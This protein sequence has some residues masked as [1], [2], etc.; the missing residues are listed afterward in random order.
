M[1]IMDN[2]YA[3]IG[4]EEMAAIY[5]EEDAPIGGDEN[6]LIPQDDNPVVR[7]DENEEAEDLEEVQVEEEVS[8]V[9]EVEEDVDDDDAEE[10]EEEYEY[11]ED[12]LDEFVEIDTDEEQNMDIDNDEEEDE[13]EEEEEEEEDDGHE[14]RID[15]EQWVWEFNRREPIE[16]PAVRWEVENTPFWMLAIRET[17]RPIQWLLWPSDDFL[18]VL[19]SCL[20]VVTVIHL[21]MLTYEVHEQTFACRRVDYSWQGWIKDMLAEVRSF[22]LEDHSYRKLPF[23]H[24]RPK[25]CKWTRYS[26]PHH[27]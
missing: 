1:N 11:F 8:E 12:H 27:N 14:G 18:L 15:M 6:A 24:P 23:F 4:G 3:P 10:V 22:L 2:D 25:D 5:Q 13:T 19:G 9:S 7:W 17:L 20:T 26:L 16:I 21:V